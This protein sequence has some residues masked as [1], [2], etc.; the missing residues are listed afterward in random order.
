M[1]G[2]STAKELRAPCT[3]N[4]ILRPQINASTGSPRNNTNASAV[5][6]GVTVVHGF[7]FDLVFTAFF[8]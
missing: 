2:V 5:E 7:D 3:I 4:P 1:N 8:I 6:N